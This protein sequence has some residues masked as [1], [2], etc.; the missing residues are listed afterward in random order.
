MHYKTRCIEPFSSYII[1]KTYDLGVNRVLEVT[2]DGD[3]YSI[4]IKD[5]VSAAEAVFPKVRWAAF[6]Y[7][8]KDID[9]EVT[10]LK[11]GKTEFRYSQQYGGGWLVSVTSGIRCVDL[12]RFFMNEKDEMKPTRHGIGLRLPEWE[13]L[14]DV[15]NRMRVDFPDLE[16]IMGCYHADIQDFIKCREC[17][18]FLRPARE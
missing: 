14:K 5:N 1:M 16:S 6:R 3:S 18:P 7:L 4:V 13:M 17:M 15:I 8:V 9:V 10:K 11:E 2:R 12:R